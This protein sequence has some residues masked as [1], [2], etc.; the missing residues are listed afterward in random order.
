MH[1][2]PQQSTTAAAAPPQP[3]L[4]ITIPVGT[5]EESLMIFLDFLAQASKDAT[6]AYNHEPRGYIDRFDVEFLSELLH[7]CTTAA[8]D[9]KLVHLRR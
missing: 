8:M 4:C 1:N 5:D 3:Q 9:A 2:N 7:K 6:F